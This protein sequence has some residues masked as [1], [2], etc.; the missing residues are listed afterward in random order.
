MARLMLGMQPPCRAGCA[1]HPATVVPPPAL[2]PG[3]CGALGQRGPGL[4]GPGAPGAGGVGVLGV[5]RGEGAEGEV[6]GE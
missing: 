4:G 5:H 1:P 6:C 2:L 3:V